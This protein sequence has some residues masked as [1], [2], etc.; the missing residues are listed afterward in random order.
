MTSTTLYDFQFT[1]RFDDEM[2]QYASF[3]TSE[4]S[5]LTLSGKRP[6][7]ED[8]SNFAV[9]TSEMLIQKPGTLSEADLSS[10]QHHIDHMTLELTWHSGKEILLLS[11]D[12]FFEKHHFLS[13][14]HGSPSDV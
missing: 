6:D 13:P 2:A 8:K 1:I 3:I 7:E 9:F 11:E 5:K 4:S 10:M 12:D 14:R